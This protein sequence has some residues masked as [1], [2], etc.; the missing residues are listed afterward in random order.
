VPIRRSLIQSSDVEDRGYMPGQNPTDL[1]NPTRQPDV[2]DPNRLPDDAF[3]DVDDPGRTPDID[4]P[5]RRPGQ[6]P[7]DIQNEE[8]D[9]TTEYPP[10][11]KS[12][13]YKMA[14]RTPRNHEDGCNSRPTPEQCRPRGF[15]RPATIARQ[16]TPR[17]Q[18]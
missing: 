17:L 4:D 2:E 3:Y 9:T 5:I 10:K 1:E 16:P 15:S 13:N 14:I 18:R 11:K 8:S 6:P 7:V 12:T